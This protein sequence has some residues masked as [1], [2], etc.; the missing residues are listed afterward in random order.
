MTHTGCLIATSDN[1]IGK[2]GPGP[3]GCGE[4]RAILHY[5]LRLWA[6]HSLQT[7]CLSD[8]SPIFVSQRHPPQ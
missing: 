7:S 4:N 8:T 6:R 1:E 3:E 5:R 2:T